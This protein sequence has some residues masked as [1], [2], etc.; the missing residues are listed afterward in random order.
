[1]SMTPWKREGSAWVIGGKRTN[2]GCIFRSEYQGEVR[3]YAS[4][5]KGGKLPPW[6]IDYGTIEAAKAAVERWLAAQRG[7]QGRKRR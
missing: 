5:W 4:A 7:K 1:M 3:F 2:G 6:V